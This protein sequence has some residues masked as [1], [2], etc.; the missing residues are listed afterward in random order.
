MSLIRIECL[1]RVITT[2]HK[3]NLADNS[4]CFP[5]R[6]SLNLRASL[7]NRVDEVFENVQFDPH[8]EQEILIYGDDRH[9]DR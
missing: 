3:S 4:P 2:L 1:R 6:V 9:G 8:F 7:G 5:E